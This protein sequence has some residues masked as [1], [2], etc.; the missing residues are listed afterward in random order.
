[1]RIWLALLAAPS[2]VLASQA[3]MYALVTPSCSMQTRVLIH[4]VALVSLALAALFA[5]LARG[6][7][8][9]GARAAPHGPDSDAADRPTSRRFLAVAATAVGGLSCLVILTMWIA[10]WV[11]SPCWQ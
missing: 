3:V 8:Q 6:D 2:L 7:W 10:A 5:L 11:L 4:I 1:M 9:R